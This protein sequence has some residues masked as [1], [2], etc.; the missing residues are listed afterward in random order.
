MSLAQT[1]ATRVRIEYATLA[2][3]NQIRAV[4]RKLGATVHVHRYAKDAYEGHVTIPYDPMTPKAED[5]R[6]AEQLRNVIRR[7]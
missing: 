7:A 1:L 5:D 3:M 6:K 2:K 4:A